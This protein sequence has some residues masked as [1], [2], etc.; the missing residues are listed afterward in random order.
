MIKRLA[1]LRQFRKGMNT[2]SYLIDELRQ[3]WIAIEQAFQ[4]I[5]VQTASSESESIAP[6]TIVLSSAVPTITAGTIL[7]TEANSEFSTGNLVSNVFYPQD[8]GLY[9][10]KFGFTASANSASASNAT[11]SCKNGTITLENTVVSISPNVGSIPITFGNTNM[12]FGNLGPNSGV[13]FSLALTNIA[14]ASRFWCEV[15]K[16]S[17]L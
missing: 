6:G 17:D 16:V 13:S 10:I 7:M 11:L 5:G 3:N 1:K 14:S 12:A 15:I 9:T 2:E 8:T 4:K